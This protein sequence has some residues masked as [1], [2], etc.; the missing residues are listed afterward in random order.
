MSDASYSIREIDR[1]IADQNKFLD[2]KFEGQNAILDRIE[3][4]VLKTNGRV[5]DLEKQVTFNR[6]FNRAIGI[7]VTFLFAVVMGVT[8]YFFTQIAYLNKQVIKQQV[9]QSKIN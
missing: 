7:V 9:L 3:K 5:S 1:I 4:Q 2:S 6:G 8:G